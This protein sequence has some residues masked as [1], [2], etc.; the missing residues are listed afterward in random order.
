MK[1]KTSYKQPTKLIDNKSF[2][3]KS[4]F[5]S[6]ALG[7]ISAILTAIPVNA[8]EK[9]YFNYRGIALSV[10]V[11]SLETF[12]KEGKI[13][14]EL[15]GYLRGVD[16]KTRDEFRKALVESQEINP[17][18]LYRFLTTPLGE[19]ILT[20]VGN[21]IQ[22]SG[23]RN[24]KY[25]IRA[26][27]VKS[28]STPEGLT[29]LNILSQ[30]PTDIELNT[31]RILTMARLVENLI[32]ETK[33]MIAQMAKLSSIEAAASDPVNFSALTDL[34][35]AGKYG[36]S[37]KTV[38]FKDE[39]RERKLTVDI[40][41]PKTWRSAGV[42]K[43]PVIV[44]SHGLASNREH[45]KRQA[46]H[47][48]S[49]GYLVA[50]PEHPESNTAQIDQMLQGYSSEI[51]KLNEFI[52]RPLDIS[53]VLD[54]LERR[55]QSEFEGRLNL[56]EVGMMGHS[57]GGYTALALA[58]ATIDFNQLEK[59]CNREVW[60]PNLS[61]L[62]QCQALKLP[63]KTYDFRDRRIKIIIALNPFNSS[64]FGAEGL[65]NIQIPVILASGSQDPA[66]PAVIEQL[67]SFIW[68][69][70]SSKYLILVEGQAH[71][72]ISQLDAGITEIIDSIPNLKLAD[73]KVLGRYGN[74]I[75]LAFFEY[76]VAKTSDYSP[77]L[78]SS[79]AQYLSEQPFG[80]YLLKS[81]S[82]VEALKQSLEEL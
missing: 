45:Y 34:R 51:F 78:Q 50:V 65:R 5:Q 38:I 71:I 30:F 4:W 24:G 59:D 33:D 82:S 68:L 80:I 66:T 76:Y 57:F 3:Q 75:N 32:A 9:I 22:I 69:Q 20:Q 61:L 46:S 49:H 37:K 10:K 43:T 1:R 44:A 79:Y 62:L 54:E 72:D 8:A 73:S 7:T 42:G 18:Q 63:R 67:R 27:V 53:Y 16:Q 13:N 17:V 74:A 39:R 64:I 28:A 48:A 29:V 11:S 81:S 2:F 23:G 26:A 36:V 35:V 14:K 56:K 52:D 15:R 55:N 47:L 25:A 60:M 40:Y 12:A 19:E 6:L 58:G 31:D 21:M 41:Q 70:N 77:Y